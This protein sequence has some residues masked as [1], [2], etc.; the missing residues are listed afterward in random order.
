MTFEEARSRIFA[1]LHST[2]GLL[3][4]PVIAK[5]SRDPSA[6][7]IFADLELDSLEAMEL[8]MNVEDDIGVE[9]GLGDLALHPSINT[10]AAALAERTSSR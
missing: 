3:N 1:A 2:H 4:D 5:K 8:C 9:V 7:V 10:L 6:D